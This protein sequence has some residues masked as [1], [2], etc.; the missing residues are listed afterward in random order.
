MPLPKTVVTR[1]PS[2]EQGR[3]LEILGHAIEYLMDS[4]VLMASKDGG[5]ADAEAALMLMRLNREVF[6]ECPEVISVKQRWW[7]RIRKYLL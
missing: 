1:R 5:R 2:R 6:A 3:A 4:Y 7:E